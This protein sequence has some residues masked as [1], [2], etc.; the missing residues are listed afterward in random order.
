M[1][2]IT[3]ELYKEWKSKGKDIF[4]EINNMNRKS[5]AIFPKDRDTLTD[6]DVLNIMLELEMKDFLL[7]VKDSYYFDTEGF[8]Y[9]ATSRLM[10][11]HNLLEKK[12][13]S[14]SSGTLFLFTDKTL[15]PLV[16]TALYDI[17]VFNC[18]NNHRSMSDL[19]YYLD[20]AEGVLNPDVYQQIRVCNIASW[21]DK[22]YR[23]AR[24][25][26]PANRKL[27]TLIPLANN[28]FEK[29]LDLSYIFEIAKKIYDKF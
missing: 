17:T 15:I 12:R 7:D 6:Y 26:N 13:K 9:E 21:V 2:F 19:I 23:Y 16:V 10:N 25:F 8:I 22:C 1:I 20:S 5:N 14:H 18:W 3:Q 28:D 27:I 24:D 11:F 4:K 29:I